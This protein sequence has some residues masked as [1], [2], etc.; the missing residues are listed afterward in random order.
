MKNSPCWKDTCSLL[1]I[2]KHY[3]SKNFPKAS[4]E[5]IV[6]QPM[7]KKGLD[8]WDSVLDLVQKE[9]SELKFKD[10]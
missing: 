3:F 1:P 5:Y 2:L 9:L 10:A 7:G 4:L 8:N 6:L